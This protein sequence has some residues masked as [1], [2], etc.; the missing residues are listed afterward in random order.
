MSSTET[1]DVHVYDITIYMWFRFWAH[2]W[3]IH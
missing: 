2:D 3:F 1:T